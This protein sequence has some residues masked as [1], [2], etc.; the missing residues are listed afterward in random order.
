L[1]SIGN[2]YAKEP[3]QFVANAMRIWKFC[4]RGCGTRIVIEGRF[5]THP[6]ARQ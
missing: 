4:N 2:L 6:R 1:F 3:R 5:L